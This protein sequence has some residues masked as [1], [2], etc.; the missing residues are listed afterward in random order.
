MRAERSRL[1]ALGSMALVFLLVASVAGPV[2]GASPASSASV[3]SAN[4][5]EEID[6]C[7]TITESGRYKLTNDLRNVSQTCIEIRSDDVTIDGAGHTVEGTTSPFAR[8]SAVRATDASNVLV[9]NL[10]VT[11]WGFAGVYF[12]GVTE[13]RMKN[14]TAT[15]NRFGLT[16]RTSERVEIENSTATNNSAG[17]IDLST[18]SQ[19]VVENNTVSD[20][21]VGISLSVTSRRN[22][23]VWNVVRDNGYGVAVSN[24]D[25]N[26]VVDNAFCGN[27]EAV[28]TLER[29]TGNTFESNEEC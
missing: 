12:R 1:V 15:R 16:V 18:T 8:R 23:V 5:S 2:A 20:N 9:M 21:P 22:R 17:G 29:S 10:T 14:V 27:E 26:E 3:A 19:S 13:S 4:H 7:T 24:S 28:V 6:S 11:N 25:Y